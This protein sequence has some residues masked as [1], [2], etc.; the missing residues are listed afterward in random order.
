MGLFSRTKAEVNTDA[1][2]IPVESVAEMAEPE[3]RRPLEQ[4]SDYQVDETSGPGWNMPDLDLIPGQ[5]DLGAY[6]SDQPQDQAPAV[7]FSLSQTE[8]MYPSPMEAPPAL[9]GV[10]GVA[11]DPA[12]DAAG[13]TPVGGEPEHHDIEIDELGALTYSVTVSGPAEE[14]VWDILADLGVTPHDDWPTIEHAARSLA[15]DPDPQTRQ[16]ANRAYVALRL[17][18]V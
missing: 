13:T 15:A 1:L 14:E 11:H 6:D 12:H 18:Q 7:D 16:T 10:A 4:L 17:L 9:A 3:R 5:F 2:E 8:S